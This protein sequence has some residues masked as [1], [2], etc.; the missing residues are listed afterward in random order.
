MPSAL[1]ASLVL[2][3]FVV[4]LAWGEL[5]ALPLS[6]EDWVILGRIAAGESGSPHVFRPLNDGWLGAFHLFFGVESALP[7][8]AGSLL[9]HLLST[10][11]LYLVAFEFLRSPWGAACVAILFGL[12]AGVV[13]TLAWVAAMPR[14]LS[15]LGAVLAWLGLVS[16]PTRGRNGLILF[17]AGYLGQFF[18]CEE[19]YGTALLAVAWFGGHALRDP[20]LR[21]V[22]WGAA[23]FVAGSIAFHYFVLNR[24]SGGAGHLQL[25]SS[26]VAAGVTTRAGQ[27]AEGLSLP[28]ESGLLVLL[29]A[30]VVLA[31]TGRSRSALFGVLAWLAAL[32]PFVFSE[33]SRYRAYPSQAP[34]ALLLGCAVFALLDRPPRRSWR[35][36]V[37][38]FIV[39]ALAFL[40]SERERNSRLA[41]WRSVLEEVRI[42]AQDSRA[43]AKELDEPPV[44]VN[45]D[46]SSA[47]PFYYFFKIL[48]PHGIKMRGFLD[49]ASAFEEPG[50]RPDGVW[51]GKRFDGTYGG[52]EPELYLAL[53]PTVEPLQLYDRA[54]LVSSL[55]EA[56]R[57]FADPSVD[58]RNVVLLEAREADVDALVPGDSE[59]GSI[60][61]LVPFEHGLNWAR[62]SVGVRASRP[63][64]LVYQEHWLFESLNRLSPDQALLTDQEELSRAVLEARNRR[65]GELLPVFHANSFAFGMLLSSGETDVELS[66]SVRH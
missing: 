56:L 32:V 49:A 46:L 27:I 10:G 57:A 2:T 19:V 48:D 54:I 23:L 59:L 52:I 66:W 53:R 18:S 60:E 4:G 45:L 30:A 41:A 39:A 35:S 24:V 28:G 40:G 29:C 8:H 22:G 61:V 33:A 31:L 47:G 1:V 13:D 37:A 50:D 38:F 21:R 26:F 9:L 62:M 64:L 25:S 58:L 14:L 34:T 7:Y 15:S 16:W 3:L 42:T 11:L 55:E 44:L 20:K 5:L 63:A 43:L 65:T 12:G 51:Y 36:V 17:L 6:G